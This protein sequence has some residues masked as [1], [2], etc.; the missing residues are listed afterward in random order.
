MAETLSL[1]VDYLGFLNAQLRDLRGYATLVNE[2]I[3]N[4]EDAHA[5]AI[6]F[7]IQEDALVVENDAL[8]SDCGHVELSECPWRHD[9]ARGHR[10]DFHRFRFTA[11]GDKRRQGDT[12]GA[13]GIGFIS[14]YQ[15][16]DRPELMCG[17]RHWAIR[18]EEPAEQRIHIRPVQGSLP[19]TRF[20]LPWA[21][22]AHS[23]IRVALGVE[24]VDPSEIDRLAVE[25]IEVLPAAMLFLTHVSHITVRRDGTEVR[26]VRR[27]RD[28]RHVTI[29]DD[30]TKQMWRLLQGSFDQEGTALRSQAG[31]FIEDTRRTTVEVAIPVGENV[32]SGRFYATLPTEHQTGLPL[33]INGDF[34]PSSDRK[35]ILL[36]VDY[37]GRWNSAAIEGAARALARGLAEVRDLMPYGA[38]WGLLNSIWEEGQKG[39]YGETPHIFWNH[40]EPSLKIVPIAYT[41]KGEWQPIKSVF[42][43]MNR[44]REEHALSILEALHQRLIHP[45][46][47]SY[48]NLLRKLGVAPFTAADLAVALKNNGLGQRHRADEVP[49]WLRSP[50]D[51]MILAEEIDYLLSRTPV[52]QLEASRAALAGCAIIVTRDGSFAPPCELWSAS[53][54]GIDLFGYLDDRGVFAA[55]GT[56]QAILQLVPAVTWKGALE[57]LERLSRDA[58]ERLWHTDDQRMLDL[59]QWFAKRSFEAQADASLTQRLR[60]VPMWLAGGT[61]DTLDNLFVPG[62]FADSLQLARLVDQRI[63]E[64]FRHFLCDVLDARDLNVVTYAR[65]LVPQAFDAGMEISPSIRRDLI[66]TLALNL[67]KLRNDA[68]VRVALMRC[69]LVE[70]SDGTFREPGAVYFATDLVREILGRSVPIAHVESPYDHAVVD[71]LRWLGVADSPRSGDILSYIKRYT[72]HP[73]QG[74]ARHRIERIF[75]ALGGAWL[76]LPDELRSALKTLKGDAWLPVQGDLRQWYSPSEVHVVRYR[77]LFATQGRFLDVPERVQRTTGEFVDYL[78]IKRRPTPSQIVSHLLDCVHRNEEVSTGVYQELNRLVPDPAIGRLKKERC[79]LIEGG[80][81]VRPAQTFWDHHPFGRYRTK[82]NAAWREYF[83]LLD[84]LEVRNSPET[85]DY[86]AILKEIS[87][88]FGSSHLD[89]EALAVLHH[90]WAMLNGAF[91]RGELDATVLRELRE[92]MVIP[93]EAGLLMPPMWLYFEDRPRLRESFAAFLEQ[94]VVTRVP[95]TWRAMQ[96]AGV[97]PLSDAV[98]TVLIE[99]QAMGTANDLRARLTER[100]PLIQ[101]VLESARGTHWDR[102]ILERLRFVRTSHLVVKHTLDAFNRVLTQVEEIR[103][104]YQVEAESLYVLQQ[105]GEIPWA[106]VARELVY[107]MNQQADAGQV[108]AALQSVLS[109]P[110]ISAANQMLDE[111]GFAPVDLGPEYKVPEPASAAPGGLDD[112]DHQGVADEIHDT[113]TAGYDAEGKELAPYGTTNDS[114]PH[115][116]AQG[117]VEE[118]TED[119]LLDQR[120]ALVGTPSQ[121]KGKTVATPT[122]QSPSGALT[123]P[124]KRPKGTK[125]GRFRTYVEPAEMEEAT[126]TDGQPG[127]DYRA[128]DRAGIDQVLSYERA[129]GRFPQEMAHNHPGYDIESADASGRILRYIEVKTVADRWSTLGVGLSKVQFREAQQRGTSYWLYVVEDANQA[130][131]VPTRI[132]DPANQVNQ[133]LYDD[134]WRELGEDDAFEQIPARRSILDFKRKT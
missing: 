93:N 128:L 74:K 86:L 95:T 67:S 16:T 3:Q 97:R 18:P 113:S 102:S 117:G 23:A 29:Q 20:R 106:A 122:A 71:L 26:S 27:L 80:V 43:L 133:F 49:N 70:C 63:L 25:M 91:D 36:D 15:V 38:F 131:E 4:A 96:A 46:L 37:Q 59:I 6:V 77:N 116:N 92:A 132:Q 54:E 79:L 101:R 124:N 65:T 5:Q 134:G 125:R 51:Q 50:R 56:P 53:P 14:V 12:I 47:N 121:A 83:A 75:S 69:P 107:A 129:C 94:N 127:D 119:V 57:I 24:P 62:D 55:T 48:A 120:D 82:L 19:S 22:D 61:P 100:G 32:V 126:L 112:M 45:T 89:Q 35:R 41:S 30:E 1:G 17:L 39:T 130:D 13:F 108:A 78:G 60:K 7:D 66:E 64:R 21:T 90:C 111:L 87:H 44:D 99:C 103:V 2:L 73:P 72:T 115:Q 109:P 84:Y 8:F 123:R 105:D 81:Y 31:R 34:F 10:C 98:T 28:G 11:S 9:P 40:L 104:Y 88:E 76:R 42:M 52:P 110:S 68:R 114:A 33:H 58:F 85:H 118:Q